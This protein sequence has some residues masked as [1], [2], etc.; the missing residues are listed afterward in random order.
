[1]RQATLVLIVLS[2]LP[3][4]ACASF[5]P[6]PL[7][8][9]RVNRGLVGQV[10][11][12]TNNHGRD[13]RIWSNALQERRDVYVY[14]PPGFDP[15]KRYPL[16]FLLHGF[17]QDESVFLAHVV[18]PLDA[19]IATGKLPPMII[20]V[21]DGSV[22]GVECLYTPGTF[23]INSRMGR[24][25]DFLMQD[26][27]SF[28]A[29]NYPIRPEPGAHAM[30]GISMGGAAAF[31]KVIKF[32]EQFRIA[33]AVFPPLNPRWESCRGRYMD[34]FDP[35]CWGW[36]TD[37]SRGREVI[38]RFYGVFTFRQRQFINPLYGRNNPATA[39]LVAENSPTEMMAAYDLKP[40]QV[41]LY[42]GYGGKDEFNLDA[43]VE[44]F[45]YVARQRGIEVGVG[46]A[47]NGRHNA[48]TGRALMPG[49]I[50]WLSP[51]LAPYAPR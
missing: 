24:F 50:E 19:A 48:A 39:A 35:N 15:C 32:R 36:R 12:H 3:L 28:V 42:V 6:R 29:R 47:P 31:A 44:S 43:Q 41:H 7:Q 40:G 22:K 18:A 11:D 46:Y 8:L 23:F 45:L 16:A 9:R 5:L 37:F 27:Y 33:A 13:N 25:E 30:L 51:R 26:V 20:V 49:M 14:L 21:P 4:P 2:L 34:N 17:L 38:G 1:M 10:I